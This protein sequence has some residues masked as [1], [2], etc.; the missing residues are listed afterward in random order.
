MTSFRLRVVLYCF[1]QLFRIPDNL[2]NGFG[3]S[4]LCLVSINTEP[5]LFIKIVVLPAAIAVR[6]SSV[7]SGTIGHLNQTMK[8]VDFFQ[9]RIFA[10]MFR[11]LFNQSLG[12]IPKFH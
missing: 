12:S 9:P 4:K 8:K 7:K 10:E 6:S 2:N 1:Q 5:L 11:I 3:C